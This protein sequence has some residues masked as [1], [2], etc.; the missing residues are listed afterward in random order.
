[1]PA[2]TVTTRTPAMPSPSPHHPG[3]ARAGRRSTVRRFGPGTT[4]LRPDRVGASA[5]GRM[6]NPPFLTITRGDGEIA[7][8]EIAAPRT[9]R[10]P[11]SSPDLL[12]PA[13]IQAEGRQ[14]RQDPIEGD[15]C[16]DHGETADDVEPVVVAGRHHRQAH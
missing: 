15:G 2:A 5:R 3:A 14:R 4:A 16:R 9:G 11:S 7:P 6:P 12:H 13:A 1:M 10:T 8:V